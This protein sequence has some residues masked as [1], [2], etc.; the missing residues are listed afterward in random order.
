MVSNYGCRQ[1]DDVLS[2]I[3]ALSA[4]VAAVVKRTEV[5]VDGGVRRDT[6]VKS[7]TPPTRGTTA[8]LLCRKPPIPL[9]YALCNRMPTGEP[10][11]CECCRI[12]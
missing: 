9:A 5:I 11:L 2:P 10:T 8:P 4:V 6:H 12:G 1:L 3:T 7:I